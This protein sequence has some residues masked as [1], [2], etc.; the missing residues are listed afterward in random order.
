MDLRDARRKVTSSCGRYSCVKGT[1]C[2]FALALSTFV[3]RSK[4]IFDK[5]GW[6]HEM[7]IVP[8]EYLF[9]G[10]FYSKNKKE[11]V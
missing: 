5:L 11:E 1:V 10:F 8:D 6:H 2:K 9:V 4:F 3:M 7:T